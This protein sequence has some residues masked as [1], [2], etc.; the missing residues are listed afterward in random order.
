[1]MI[2]GSKTPPIVKIKDYFYRVEFQQ[3]GSPHI[4]MLVWVNNAPSISKNTVEE[5]ADF[6]N[7]YITC[8]KNDEIEE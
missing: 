8:K 5:I 3:R 2:L 6:V 1:M 7:L 4:H